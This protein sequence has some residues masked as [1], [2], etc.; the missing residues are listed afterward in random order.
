MTP[1]DKLDAARGWLATEADQ[2]AMDAEIDRLEALDDAGIEQELVASGL[3]VTRADTVFARAAARAGV[4]IPAAAPSAVS[5][6]T[7]STR[8]PASRR[9]VELPRARRSTWVPFLIAAALGTAAVFA[10][11]PRNV[12]FLPNDGDTSSRDEAAGIRE[13]ALLACDAG[14]WASCESKLDAARHLDPAGEADPR[15][16][17]ARARIAAARP[18][19]APSP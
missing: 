17:A 5:A 13:Q 19:G 12:V 9:V 2:A 4:S 1:D 14:G 16:K 15:I 3:D 7:A 6:P 18:H 8:A 10:M 11:Q